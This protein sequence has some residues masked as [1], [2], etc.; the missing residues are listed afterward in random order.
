MDKFKVIDCIG[1]SDED[2]AHLRLLLRSAVIHLEERWRWG[3]EERADLVVVDTGSLVGDSALRRTERRGVACARLIAADAPAPGGRYLRK[4][5]RRDDLVALLNGIGASTVAPMQLVTQG[6]DFFDLDLGETDAPDADLQ[7]FDFSLQ[8]NERDREQDAFEALFHRDPAEDKPMFLM[9]EK[10]QQDTGVEFVRDATTRSEARADSYGNPFLRDGID[11]SLID[12][13]FRRGMEHVFDDNQTRTLLEWLEHGQ[14]GGPA[15]IE[16]PGSPALVVDPKAQV[17]HSVGRLN[18]LEAYFGE[19]LR[20]GDWK[21]LINSE[22]DAWRAKAPARPYQRLLWMDR[23][24]RSDGY[25]SSHLDPA[26]SYRLTRW[27]ELAQEYP[28]AFRIGANMI[29]AHRLDEIAR[30]SEVALAEVFDVVNAYE[31]IGFVEWTRRQRG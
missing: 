22:L 14:L 27:L 23:Y 20:A 18:A 30:L 11:E 5:L 12:P 13:S 10:L 17:F 25:L 4:P 7:K 28:R 1:A 29:V 3:A 21:R 6:E 31:A 16:R 26:G 8:R 9:P 24:L 2:V 15:L 19:P